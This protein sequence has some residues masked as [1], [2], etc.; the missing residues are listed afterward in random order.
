MS[1]IQ[2]TDHFYLID[3]SGI[4]TTLATPTYVPADTVTD[5]RF[6]PNGQEIAV[7]EGDDLVIVDASTAPFSEVERY[8]LGA[9]FL[10]KCVEWDITGSRLFVGRTDGIL[11][12]DRA[13]MTLQKRIVPHPSTTDITDII[14]FE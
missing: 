11:I 7:I 1:K 2:K 12:I 4:I 6:S 3:G 8:D 14:Y 10:K 9:L 13:T 5:T